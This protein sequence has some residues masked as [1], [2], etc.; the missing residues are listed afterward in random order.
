MRFL[1]IDI[2]MFLVRPYELTK[3][4]KK[5]GLAAEYIAPP[6]PLGVFY[7]R[8]KSYTT[9]ACGRLRQSL[10]LHSIMVDSREADPP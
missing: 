4:E 10:S 3:W 8:V 9:H 5:G 7:P 2:S 6:N 1:D